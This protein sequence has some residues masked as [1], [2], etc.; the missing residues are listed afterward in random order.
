MVLELTREGDGEGTG[1]DGPH[2]EH[3]ADRVTGE[4]GFDSIRRGDRQ[5]AE[6]QRQQ[7]QRH[8]GW[9]RDERQRAQTRGPE[10]G[11]NAE[12]EPE[13]SEPLDARAKGDPRLVVPEATPEVREAHGEPGGRQPDGD[14]RP[15]ATPATSGRRGGCGGGRHA[16]D[17]G[18]RGVASGSPP[19]TGIVAPVVGVWRVAKK[20]T[21]RP[22]CSAVTR[23]FSRLRF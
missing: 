12:R 16:T 15:Q 13:L 10:R 20:R 19:S 3:A 22:T 21:A 14:E 7:P 9:S 5:H 18:Y 1:R 6:G 2:R 8:L 11:R 4:R 17:R 23:A